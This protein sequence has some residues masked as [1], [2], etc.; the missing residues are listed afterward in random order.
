M[1]VDTSIPVRYEGSVLTNSL[2]NVEPVNAP[3]YRVF[4]SVL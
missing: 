2:K 3:T 1:P 4:V